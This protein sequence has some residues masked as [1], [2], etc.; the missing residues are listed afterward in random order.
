MLHEIG[1]SGLSTLLEEGV[2]GIGLGNTALAQLLQDA[3]VLLA[4]LLRHGQHLA[5]QPLT[6]LLEEREVLR[7][8]VVEVLVHNA[9][10]VVEVRDQAVHAEEFVHEGAEIGVAHLVELAARMLCR[11]QFLLNEGIHL[12]VLEQRGHLEGA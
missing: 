2:R 3:D 10:E 4:E 1:G 6:A 5:G 12:L 9:Q 11:L 7:L 8:L